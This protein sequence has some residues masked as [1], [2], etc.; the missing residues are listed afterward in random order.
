MI[1]WV[2]KRNKKAVR[3]RKEGDKDRKG[4]KELFCLLSFL[5]CL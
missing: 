4:R 5:M 3:E 2:N 1:G